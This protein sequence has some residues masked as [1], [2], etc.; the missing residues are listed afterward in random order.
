MLYEVITGKGAIKWLDKDK[1]DAILLDVMMPELSG[2]ETCK[3]IKQNRLFKDIPIL[4]LTARNDVDSVTEGFK[5]G[6]VDY[7]YKPFNHNEL[8]V[9]IN[10]HV[11][12]K[13]AKDVITSYSIHYT[14]LYEFDILMAE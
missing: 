3:L 1:F 11:E 14:K 10:T 9:R 6:G 12:L 8:L 13:L 4:F 5:V 7:I 2:F